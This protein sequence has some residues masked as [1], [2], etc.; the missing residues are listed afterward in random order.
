MEQ[1]FWVKNGD[2]AEVNKWLQKGGIVKS[3][4]AVSE[5]ISSYGLSLI[6]IYEPTRPY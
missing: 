3:I 5:A 1:I 2:L 4:H 6:H